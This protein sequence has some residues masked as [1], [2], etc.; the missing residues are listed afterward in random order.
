LRRANTVG[1]DIAPAG[2]ILKGRVGV[3]IEAYIPSDFPIR[4]AKSAVPGHFDTVELSGMSGFVTPGGPAPV[5]RTIP[6]GISPFI[7]RVL[8]HAISR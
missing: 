1:L 4:A 8:D 3:T 2:E 5:R 6:S 7:Q